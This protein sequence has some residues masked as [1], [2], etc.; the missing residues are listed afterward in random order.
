MRCLLMSLVFLVF[1]AHVSAKA[2]LEGRWNVNGWNDNLKLV[3]KALSDSP[4]GGYAPA[5]IDCPSTRPVVR[6]ANGISELERQWLQ[7]RRPRT[8]GPMK[9][10]LGRL[11]I[12]GFDAAA[13]IDRHS[14]NISSLPNIAIAASGGG[15][16][17]LNNG[18]GGLK[19]FDSRS[20]NSS[21]VGQL[22]G[23]LQASSYLA[24]LSGGSWL[25]GSMYI[26]N[27]TSVQALQQEVSGSLW[28]FGRTVVEGPDR[29][30]IA[31]AD[32]SQY[33]SSIIKSVNQK[34]DGGFDTSITDLWGRGLSFQMVNFT[35]GGPGIT[36]SSI[37]DSDFFKNGDAPMPIALADGRAPGEKII[38]LNA[39]NFEFNPYEMGSFDPSLY[40]FVPLKFL[41]S[42]FSGGVLPGDQKCIAGFDN[43]GFVIGTSSSLFNNIFNQIDGLDIPQIAKSLLKVLTASLTR[44]DNDIAAY[45][46][47]PF[48]HFNNGSNPSAPNKQLTLVDGGEDNQNLPLNPLIQPARAIDVI[49][50][51]DGSADTTTNWP[52]GSSLVAT[53]ERSKNETMQNGTAFPSIPD[54]NT[55]INLGLN[56]K[57]TFFGCD[58]K[59]LSGPSPLLVYIPN[60]P[61][62]FASNITTATLR[63]A[64][65][66]RDKVID[67]GYLVATM[68]NGTLDKTWPTCVG[69]AILSRSLSR[70]GTEV[71]AACKACFDRF[72][73]NGTLDT[74]PVP[75]RFEPKFLLKQVKAAKAGRLLAPGSGLSA[76]LAISAVIFMV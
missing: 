17:A 41:G 50:A 42:N 24:G 11:K 13:Y 25:V 64:D 71:P 40:G 1:S 20:Q 12:D 37:A 69:C 51:L 73:W 18:A 60:T 33:W 45:E 9:D 23:L 28:E 48:F 74:R 66:V 62:T 30:G 68:A 63:Y 46:P 29:G 38:S 39:T 10:L 7:V 54:F 76:F 47:N 4:S 26:N 34:R 21:N 72:C 53:Y 35:E 19:A 61:Y 27:F 56:T 5:P 58:I 57:P 65:D 75:D 14:Q 3:E 67:N 31:I 70:T 49:F 2:S 6:V 55:F 22:G 43:A 36:W 44:A 32:K 59:N 16:R 52:N 15:Y 8:L